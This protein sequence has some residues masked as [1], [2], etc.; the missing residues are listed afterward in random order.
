MRNRFEAKCCICGLP[1]KPYTGQIQT[2]KGISGVWVRHDYHPADGGSTCDMAR[3][4]ARS[5][6]G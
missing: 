4:E 1:V 2:Y 6:N 3:A 5:S